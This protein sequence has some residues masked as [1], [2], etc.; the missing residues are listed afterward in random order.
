MLRALALFSLLLITDAAAGGSPAA[1]QSP[2]ASPG[3]AAPVPLA[4]HGLR[5]PASFTGTLPCAD[6]AGIE[7][8]LDLWPDQAYAMRRRWLGREAPL[9][10]D[11]VG[12]WYVDPG[13]SALILYGASEQPIEWEIEAPDRLRL[14]DR[15]G[16]PIV[17]DLPYA[18]SAGPLDPVPLALPLSGMVTYLADSAVFRECLTGHRFPVVPEADRPALEKAYLAARPAP[19][20]SVLATL[21]GR[22]ETRP[23]MEGP[24][25]RSLIVERFE[26]MHPQQ[27]CPYDPR[28]PALTGTYWRL[29]HIAGAP[30]GGPAGRQ[31]PH[32]L[33][34]DGEGPPRFSAT[35]G[36]N[37]LA[38]A[39]S[40]T[41]DALS[42]GPVR[43]TMMACPPT[44]AERER[45]LSAGLADTAIWTISGRTLVLEDLRGAPLLRAE[46][47][48]TRF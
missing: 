29:V 32:L 15:T 34:L 30:P 5:Q 46:A 11:E 41:G 16:E 33:L 27:G 18:L 24:A 40:R 35:A 44:L 43:S 13:R 19:G 42:F 39:W 8:H 20:A 12:R 28:P 23:A 22:I 48:Y 36:C 3:P 25:R 7:H 4:A 37:W 45:A 1:A 31:E 14:L 21:E 38:G 10:H 17:S 26:R 2:D 47:A 9:V 6:C